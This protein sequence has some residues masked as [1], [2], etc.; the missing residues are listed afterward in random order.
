MEETEFEKRKKSVAPIVTEMIAEALPDDVESLD[1]TEELRKPPEE[2]KT[3]R[4]LTVALMEI[5]CDDEHAKNLA[6]FVFDKKK[7][8]GMRSLF[9]QENTNDIDGEREIL[10]MLKEAVEKLT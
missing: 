3:A 9:E 6:A 1:L 5:G 8:A 7:S 10:E 4:D 2:I